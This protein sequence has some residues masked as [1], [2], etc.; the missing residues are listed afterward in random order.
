[1]VPAKNKP[2]V[3]IVVCSLAWT[4]SVRSLDCLKCW[5]HKISLITVGKNWLVYF[6]KQYLLNVESNEFNHF[7]QV[8]HHPFPPN[9]FVLCCVWFN[10]NKCILT[11]DLF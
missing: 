6:K 8:A 2:M 1:L 4:C 10:K 5:C 11:L 3:P 9:A 7:S